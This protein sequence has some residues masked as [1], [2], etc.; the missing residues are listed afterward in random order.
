MD[1]D[2]HSPYWRQHP[3]DDEDLDL[4]AMLRNKWF[5]Y[6]LAGILLLP[7]FGCEDY[8]RQLRAAEFKDRFFN[9]CMPR[10]GDQVIASWIEGELICK[11][12]TPSGRYAKT[13]PHAEVRVAT[14]EDDL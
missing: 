8:D 11:R 13:F 9:G 1:D 6:L 10:K 4:I 7:L 5:W 3:A 12:I 14:I 2:E